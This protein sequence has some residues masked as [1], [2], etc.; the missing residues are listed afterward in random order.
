CSTWPWLVPVIGP[1][2]LWFAWRC[3]P[4][5]R[6]V[7]LINARRVLGEQSTQA[8]RQRLAKSLLKNF[9]RFIAAI[10]RNRRRPLNEI[11]ADIERIEGLEA[12]Q[13]VR[14]QRR[15]AILA[16]AH[17]GAFEIAVAGL[18]QHEPKVHVVFRRDNMPIFE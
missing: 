15:G 1:F 7:G 9:C 16:A 14:S 4:D 5:V 2:F 13:A 6:S 18:R 8:E 10:G 12:Y 17:L 11:A 3:S